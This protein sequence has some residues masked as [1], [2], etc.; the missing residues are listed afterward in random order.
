MPCGHV[1]SC[2][3]WS[4]HCLNDTKMIRRSLLRY[5]SRQGIADVSRI[6]LDIKMR[7]VSK[8]SSRLGNFG[9]PAFFW[10]P[11]AFFW[12]PPLFFDIPP[13]LFWP[14]ADLKC[15]YCMATS[16]WHPPCFFLTSP[17]DPASA[18]FWPPPHFI[19]TSPLL[20]FDLPTT[21][22][23]LPHFSIMTPPCSF[24]TSPPA[25]FFCSFFR[26]VLF[27]VAFLLWCCP[28]CLLRVPA[29]GWP[30]C[31]PFG[32]P[33]VGMQY[34]DL[35][36]QYSQHEPAPPP[37]PPAATSTTTQTWHATTKDSDK[38]NN[39]DNKHNNNNNNNDNNNNNNN[40]N[41][42]SNNNKGPPSHHPQCIPCNECIGGEALRPPPY[43]PPALFVFTAQRMPLQRVYKFTNLR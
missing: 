26:C 10:P 17:H 18:L 12:P 1:S 30:S 23:W 36:L 24:L 19:L 6:C 31:K 32:R 41:N 25:P 22:F 16:F 40:S 38:D 43:P 27:F 42:N 4:A 37:Q 35:L 33:A 5:Q 28:L 11:P 34:S 7:L 14:P 9:G 20:F 13:A 39:N 8:I 15:F 2:L 21:S 3:G 29:V